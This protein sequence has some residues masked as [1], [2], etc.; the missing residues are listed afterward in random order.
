MNVKIKSWQE[1]AGIIKKEKASGKTIGFTNGCFDILHLGHIKYLEEA[2]SNCDLLVV[3]VNSDGSVKSIK[4][5]SR[6]VNNEKARTEVLAA[7][8][9]VDFIT[10][11]DEDTPEH[12]IKTLTPGV[13]FKGGDWKEEDIVGADHVKSSGGKVQ[14]IPYIEGYSTTEMIEKI[15]KI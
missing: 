2:R 15:K 6:P 4:G 8:E 3:G 1:L 7:L 11:F 10:L 12:L 9:S 14:V 13:L 5:D